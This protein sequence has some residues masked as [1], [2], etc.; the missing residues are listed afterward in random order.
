MN[1]QPW[2]FVLISSLHLPY[3]AWDVDTIVIPALIRA[4]IP[5]CSDTQLYLV[6]ITPG[7]RQLGGSPILSPF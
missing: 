5:V 1:L 4:H 6:C 7:Q 3:Q 2:L